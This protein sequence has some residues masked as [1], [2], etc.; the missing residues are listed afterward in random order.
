MDFEINC[1][2]SMVPS[3]KYNFLLKGFSNSSL[4]QLDLFKNKCR[5]H[6]YK[7]IMEL[8]KQKVSFYSLGDWEGRN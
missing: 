1:Q 2:N 8:T 4:S 6:T 7:I 5:N 3:L